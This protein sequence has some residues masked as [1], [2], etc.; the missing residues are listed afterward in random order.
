MKRD[1]RVVRPFLS[2]NMINSG[3]WSLHTTPANVLKIQ[4]LD[5]RCRESGVEEDP[6]LV[7]A[8]KLA[9]ELAAIS[10]KDVQ[11]VF[12][13]PLNL[14][15]KLLEMLLYRDLIQESSIELSLL[16]TLREGFLFEKDLNE[17]KRHRTDP[18]FDQMFELT[19]AGKLAAEAGEIR[20]V[21]SESRT[22]YMIEET[23]EFL[24]LNTTF[25]A[26]EKFEEIQWKTA[27]KPLVKTAANW[28]VG[29]ERIRRS[30]DETIEGVSMN[31]T[32][33]KD[34]FGQEVDI[35][36][37]TAIQ[38]VQRAVIPGIWFARTLVG[39]PTLDLKKAII[40]RTSLFTSMG[41]KSITLN[42]E[43]T[44]RI[45][46]IEIRKELSKPLVHKNILSAHYPNHFDRDLPNKSLPKPHNVSINLGN[47]TVLQ[48]LVRPIPTLKKIKT[49]VDDAIDA[50]MRKLPDG[51]LG[52]SEVERELLHLR[53]ATSE[54]WLDEDNLSPKWITELKLQ[55]ESINLDMILQRYRQIGE[56][57]LQYR[58]DESEV[59]IHAN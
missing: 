58:V 48:A 33:R 21:I 16:S 26:S 27:P 55:L 51:S 12:G 5:L 50:A 49:W 43:I 4:F 37:P 17:E 19:E 44:G 31:Q 18:Q 30:V 13:L 8:T 35:W 34:D 53:N 15:R 46:A 41:I 42:T 20:P 25:G 38:S 54:I 23:G 52:R 6:L 36:K 9:N 1:P 39:T 56:W 24:P 40:E 45:G 22:M 3:A 47:E 10:A 32:I 11:Q 28:F 2:K 57:E 14:S 7:H 59:F 29:E